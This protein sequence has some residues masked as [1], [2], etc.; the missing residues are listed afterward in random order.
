MTNKRFN[1]S[2]LVMF[3][4]MVGALFSVNLLVDPYGVLGTSAMPAGPSSNERYLKVEHLKERVG[5]YDLLM[6][7]S[8]RSGMTD[9]NWVTEA[10]GL[11]AYNLSVFSGKP[12]DMAALYGAYRK[13]NQPP[14]TVM[15]GIDAMAFLLESAD[16]DLSRRHHPI[17]VETDWLGFW[18]DYLLAPSLLPA[19]E[20][21]NAQTEPTISF[22]WET[23]TYALVG[24][25]RE[26]AR[27]HADYKARKFEAWTPRRI[28]SPL[29]P[30]QWRAF[31]SWLERMR[32]E[33]V[34]VHVFLQPMHRQ[35]RERMAPLMPELLALL[36]SVQNWKDLSY[37]GSDRDDDWYEQRHYREPIAREVVNRLFPREQQLASAENP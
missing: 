24:Y 20:K 9:P 36:N 4:L 13:L 7:G 34:E 3:T 25:E 15:V 19:M 14:K 26:I 6:F 23:G 12:T 33:N 5:Q 30:K 2:V 17:A 21:V 8:S 37:V 11:E 29:D 28:A 27:D 16:T 31:E 18:L 1:V 35:W 32:S 10:T 22:D